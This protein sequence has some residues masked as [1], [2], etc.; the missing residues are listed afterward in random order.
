MRPQL[1]P[2]ILLVDDDLTQMQA[3][4]DILSEAGYAV[5]GY[6]DPYAALASLQ[7]VN[8]ELML[9]DLVMPGM[10]GIELMQAAHQHNPDI[11]CL[12]LTGMASIASAVE[13][14]KLGAIDY[15]V[16]PFDMR[17]LRPALQRAAHQRQFKIDKMIATLALKA[18]HASLAELNQQLLAAHRAA[19]H[20]NQAKSSMLSHLSHD[21]RTPLN[22]IQ[23]FA[24]ILQSDNL[25]TTEFQRKEFAGHILSASKH[26]IK[27]ADDILDLAKVESGKVALAPARLP[28][29]PI[30]SDCVQ[31]IAPLC[32]ERQISLS[33]EV[34]DGLHITADVTRFKQIV[35]NLLSNA[36][37]FNREGGSVKLDCRM[38]GEDRVTIAVSDTGYGIPADQLSRLFQ[39]FERLGHEKTGVAGTGLGLVMVKRLTELMGGE[40][41]AC[42]ELSVGSTF[43][44]TLPTD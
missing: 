33:A 28:L 17:V 35:L 32:S 13:A 24:H 40:I 41:S 21:I 1:P 5:D 38:A 3:I 23:G 9:V 29:K 27:L 37:K 2:T 44:F 16:K 42:S 4:S 10:G 31:I 6:T 19:E 26:V 34:P 7:K 18:S 43:A 20:A 25:P 12:I 11:G 14:L 22:A 15:L 36:V 30:V 8:Y 39:P